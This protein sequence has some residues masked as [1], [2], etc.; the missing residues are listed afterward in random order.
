MEKPINKIKDMQ[1]KHKGWYQD[2]TR[3]RTWLD[4]HALKD[5]STLEDFLSKVDVHVVD[6]LKDVLN[7]AK[8]LIK[9]IPTFQ[10]I[11]KKWIT[12]LV[13]SMRRAGVIKD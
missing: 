4:D 9:D 5:M 6:A 2:L 1:A 3:V 8:T 13:E 10:V 7:A 12:K 11:T